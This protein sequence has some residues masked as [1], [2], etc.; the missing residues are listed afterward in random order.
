MHVID[1]CVLWCERRETGRVTTTRLSGLLL[2]E[3]Q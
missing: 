2:A 3:R 1:V